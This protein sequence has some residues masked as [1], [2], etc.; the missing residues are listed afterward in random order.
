MH[1]QIQ[2]HTVWQTLALH[3]MPGALLTAFYFAIAPLVMRAGYPA[4]MALFLSIL[5][6]LLP[7]ELGL[8]LYQGHKMNGRLSLA[9]VVLNRE[10][11]PFW[12]YVVFVPLLVLWGGAAFV[13]LSPLD[14]DLLRTFFAWLPSWSDPG[15]FAAAAPHYPHSVLLLLVLL[16]FALN[17]IA[18]PVVEEL[19]FRGFLMPHIPSSGKW[20]PLINV[21]LFSLYHFFS[22]WQFVTRIVAVIPFAYVVSWKRNLYL[23]MLTHCLLNIL[24]MLSLLALLAR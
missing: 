23:G 18:G 17:G 5:V 24:G 22:P 15:A 3:L 8:L 4:L 7:F 11:I 1:Q 12:Q 9:G 2:S 16:G 13:G 21:V 19:Y 6:I 14:D 20:A 10:P